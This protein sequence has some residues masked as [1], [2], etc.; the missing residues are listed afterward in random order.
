MDLLLTFAVPERQFFCL[1]IFCLPQDGMPSRHAQAMRRI[2]SM[3][4]FVVIL[5][6][7]GWVNFS[8]QRALK[9]TS[10]KYI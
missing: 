8:L 2:I 3:T 1:Y 10:G 9:N 5:V 6:G 7:Q 4:V